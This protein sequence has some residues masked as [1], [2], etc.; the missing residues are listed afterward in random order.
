MNLSAKL[1]RRERDI[2]ELLA[3]GATKKEVATHLFIS[4]RTV[5]NHTRNIFEKTG[6][7]KVNQLSAWWFCDQYHIPMS[8]SPLTKKY[9]VSI[10]F[11]IY[12]FGIFSGTLDHPRISA[13]QSR[14]ITRTY[15][16]QRNENNYQYIYAA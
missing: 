10:L 8:L 12:S 5:E 9:V 15:R 1:T 6:C 3:W 16:C 2:T 13:T 4:E 7:T 11:V 14:T